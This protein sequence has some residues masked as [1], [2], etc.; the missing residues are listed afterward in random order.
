MGYNTNVSE[1]ESSRRQCKEK[2]KTIKTKTPTNNTRHQKRGGHY[3]PEAIS[4]VSTKR[5]TKY[6]MIN[7]PH[8]EN[9]R[10]HNQTSK[11][12]GEQK[13]YAVA[14]QKKGVEGKSCVDEDLSN[15][16]SKDIYINNKN[17]HQN[18][19]KDV[20]GGNATENQADQRYPQGLGSVALDRIVQQ[21][22]K[23]VGGRGKNWSIGSSRLST[24]GGE[25][26]VVLCREATNQQGLVVL[27]FWTRHHWLLVV[28]ENGAV[29]FY[30]SAPSEPV[31]RDVCRVWPGAV[32]V[33]TITQHRG[34]MQCGLFVI[35]HLLEMRSYGSGKVNLGRMWD[36]VGGNRV[37]DEKWVVEARRLVKEA[38]WGGADVVST[39][40]KPT[41]G[42]VS[43]T[44]K[45][46][47]G[48]VST[49][50]KPTSGFTSAT[51]TRQSPQGGH[52]T[53]D[54]EETTKICRVRHN[55]YSAKVVSRSEKTSCLPQGFRSPAS[56]HNNTCISGGGEEFEMNTAI[57]V[58]NKLEALAARKNLCYA[59]CG[60]ILHHAAAKSIETLSSLEVSGIAKTS[61]RLRFPP[62]TEQDVPEFLSLL[63]DTVFVLETVPRNREGMTFVIIPPFSPAVIPKRGTFVLGARFI[64]RIDPLAG[65]YHGHWR[66]TT[67]WEDSQVALLFLRSDSENIPRQKNPSSHAP[68]N[69][70]PSSSSGVNEIEINEP[71]EIKFSKVRN[72]E[73]VRVSWKAFGDEGVCIGTLMQRKA[74]GL[75]R[76]LIIRGT[77]CQH[78]G[79]L[80]ECEQEETFDFPWRAVQYREVK[81]LTET[82]VWEPQCQAALDEGQQEGSNHSRRPA[83]AKRET[84]DGTNPS[85]LDHPTT[86]RQ[87]KDECKDGKTAR[88]AIDITD[89]SLRRSVTNLTHDDE[90]DVSPRNIDQRLSDERTKQSIVATNRHRG[91]GWNYHEEMTNVEQLEAPKNNVDAFV[92]TPHTHTAGTTLFRAAERFDK[93]IVRDVVPGWEEFESF[94]ELEEECAQRA[95]IEIPPTQSEN[96]PY[97]LPTEVSFGELRQLLSRP[98]SSP[99]PI[100]VAAISAGTRAEHERILALLC[101]APAGYDRWPAARGA[102]EVIARTARERRW[103]ASTS[104]KKVASLQGAM[105]MLPMY[106][107]APPLA[108]GNL[109]EWKQ[110]V[111]ALGAKAREEAP[112]AIVPAS[113]GIIDKAIRLSPRDVVKGLLAL[114]WLTAARVGDLLQLAPADVIWQPDTRQL[115]VTYRRGKTVSRRGPFSLHTE[116]PKAWVPH[117]DKSWNVAQQRRR[118]FEAVSVGEVTLALRR[119]DSRLESRSIR[120]GSLQVMAV[121]GVPEDT[122]VLFSGHTTLTTLRRYLAW[123]AIGTVKKEIMTTAARSL[124]TAESSSTKKELTGGGLSRKQYKKTA[125]TTH[126]SS[127]TRS[128]KFIR[129]LGFDAPTSSEFARMG[130]QKPRKNG[131]LPLHI[132]NVVGNADWRNILKLDCSP[133]LRKLAAESFRYLWDPTV[134]PKTSPTARPP[135]SSAVKLPK[136]DVDKL[137]AAQK[138]RIA[139]PNGTERGGKLFAVA[140]LEK[141]R[142]RPIWEPFI[143]DS[144]D[145]V[146]TVRFKSLNERRRTIEGS[147]YAI[148]F[149]FA[150]YYD[151]FAI[152]ESVARI[153]GIR[154]G[155]EA[156]LPATLPMGFRPSCQVAQAATWIIT[157]VTNRT[158]PSVNILTYIDNVLILGANPDEVKSAADTFTRICHNVNVTV[159]EETIGEVV[160]TRF[161]FLGEKYDL[162][163]LTRSN[164]DKTIRKIG[165]VISYIEKAMAASEARVIDLTL[166]RREFAAIFGIAIFA[167][168]TVDFSLA[169]VFWPFRAYRRIAADTHWDEWEAPTPPLDRPTISTL[170]WWLKTLQCNRAVPI[171]TS[172]PPEDGTIFVD[173]SGTGWGAVS[174]TMTGAMIVHGT[175]ELTEAASMQHSV[176]AEPAGVWRAMCRFISPDWR[177]VV[178]VTDHEPLAWAGMAGH[179]KGYS[180]NELIKKIGL[181]WPELQVSW[182]FIAG[183]QNPADLPSRGLGLPSAQDIALAKESLWKRDPTEKGESQG[184]GEDGE[185]YATAHNPLKNKKR[186]TTTI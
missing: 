20:F 77:Q 175:W 114:A 143:N 155:E 132:K 151:Q 47:S 139:T 130:G 110:G 46:T 25:E 145:D 166:S 137:I 50:I 68:R 48:H 57:T 111:R 102:L 75:P 70:P 23:L 76:R 63:G 134:F 104:A 127:E 56:C 49:T 133:V 4:N 176:T 156:L 120:R 140:E 171:W 82:E 101:S 8:N 80:H 21:I 89:D 147:K 33:P 159:N 58:H 85:A 167:S 144:F 98:R 168:R 150:A 35:A 92:P 87:Q 84:E 165:I 95:S 44:S 118:L 105:N 135:E 149:D 136:D 42:H 122:L 55:P 157:D 30:D 10:N 142:R 72:G 131:V 9:K 79:K 109:P 129:N 96:R 5:E 7:T 39:T 26:S 182:R 164:T 107:D 178:I 38:V 43:T 1:K 108:L 74:P 2:T 78:C 41:S 52:T 27:P 62:G 59:L 141:Q 163:A 169:S 90:A 125:T 172:T 103:K 161:D 71:E 170:L 148:Q 158:V 173:A 152:E 69:G 37:I 28:A 53:P 154:R 153:L 36:L 177:H 54:L 66:I 51:N 86:N 94:P 119:V 16:T 65:A 128:P 34:S 73:R 32:R 180:Y 93:T 24:C 106:R 174:C 181:A 11:D 19:N 146:P 112:R 100:A 183:C 83:E 67:T 14:E 61:A 126:V 184:N 88:N 162:Q 45:P 15:K 60:T 124:A 115:T 22:G 179:A 31:R 17:N 123:G 12:N 99:H 18:K 91:I 185:W 29:R 117:I 138:I 13:S 160:C 113:F 64:G 81:V 97:H 3:V 6:Q 116:V 121:E 186:K 40:T